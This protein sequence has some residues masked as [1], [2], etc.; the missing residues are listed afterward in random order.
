M[1]AKL[2]IAAAKAHLQ[3]V[4]ADEMM[5]A[6][7]V[8]EIWLEDDGRIWCVTLSFFRK[9]DELLTNVAGRF[10][11]NDSKV[12]RIENKAGGGPLSIKD[13]VRVAA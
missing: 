6:A 4:F 7:R 13:R 12:I 2:A 5:S 11:T 3:D 10:A 1:D 9:P 8:E